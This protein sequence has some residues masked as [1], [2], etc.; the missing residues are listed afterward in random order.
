LEC[1]L[2]M[3]SSINLRCD[4][5]IGDHWFAFSKCREIRASRIPRNRFGQYSERTVAVHKKQIE[6]GI[7]RCALFPYRHLTLKS[8]R[9]LGSWAGIFREGHGDWCGPYTRNCY[10]RAFTLLFQDVHTGDSLIRIAL[11]A[12]SGSAV[13]TRCIVCFVLGRQLEILSKLFY[14]AARRQEWEWSFVIVTSSCK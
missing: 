2:Q 6:Q 5:A 3:I 14:E 12:V 4:A 9:C 10:P 8:D 11:P 1:Q 13:S 7:S